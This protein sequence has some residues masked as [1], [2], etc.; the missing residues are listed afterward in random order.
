MCLLFSKFRHNWFHTFI[1]ASLSLLIV[2]CVISAPLVLWLSIGII[3]PLS[4]QC[5]PAEMAV[6][7]VLPH[8]AELESGLPVLSPGLGLMVRDLQDNFDVLES[9]ERAKKPTMTADEFLEPDKKDK[10]RRRRRWHQATL[11]SVEKL[12]R[13]LSSSRK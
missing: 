7:A 11:Q 10:T 2:M 8:T 13:P 9:L 6:T 4:V 5:T 1:Q 3:V 12:Q